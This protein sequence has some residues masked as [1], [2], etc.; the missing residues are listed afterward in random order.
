[1]I[2][3]GLTFLTNIALAEEIILNVKGHEGNA[4][5]Y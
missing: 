2:G 1:M 5:T 4:G 3:T